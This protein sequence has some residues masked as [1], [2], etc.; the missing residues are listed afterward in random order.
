MTDRSKAAPSATSLFLATKPKPVRDAR[1]A[2]AFADLPDLRAPR[3]T[4]RDTLDYDPTP[5]EASRAF[6][7]AEAPRI[8]QIGGAVWEPAAGGGHMVS[9]LI[10]YGFS[11]VASDI[12]DRGCPDVILRGFYD[13]DEAPSP[14][15]ITNPPYCEINARDGHGRWLRH[16]ISLPGVRY[17]AFLLNWDWPAARKNGL[18]E[19][20]A[21]HPISRAYLC[22]WKSDFRGGGAPPQRNGWFVWDADHTGETVMRFLDRNGDERQGGFDL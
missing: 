8:R 17:V 14:I 4:E 5:P 19:L 1:Q 20:L 22:R 9:P 6:L 18:D 3:R 2:Q 10:E 7:A 12:V 16:A 15:I 13:Y 21:A 11:V